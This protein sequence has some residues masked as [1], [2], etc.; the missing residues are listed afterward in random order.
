MQ[1]VDYA[2]QWADEPMSDIEERLAW[3][4][5]H[6]RQSCA[7]PQSSLE[8]RLRTFTNGS[9]HHVWQCMGCGEQ[10]GN[11]LGGKAARALLG[12][13]TA[14]AFDDQ[15][16]EEYFAQRVALSTEHTALNDIKLA[17]ERPEVLANM[18]A[19]READEARALRV[20]AAVARCVE[21]LQR[22]ITEPQV[23]DALAKEAIAM[24]RRHR[25]VLI[26]ATNRFRS[27]PELKEW[28]EL[29][30]AQ[31]FI[32][33]PEVVGKHTSEGVRVQIDYVAYPRQHLIDHGFAPVYFGIEVK[34]LDQT[35]GFTHKASRAVWQTVSYT[36][37]VFSVDGEMRRLKFALLF[38]N[39]GFEGE[40][41]L[42]ENLGMQ[43][44]N[45]WV[46]WKSLLQLAN[47]ANV[48][49]LDILGT[50]DAW[51][52]WSMAFSSGRYFRRTKKEGAVAY[53]LS[54]AR[55]INKVRIGNF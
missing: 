6:L 36:D 52:G 41:A 23:A 29:H 47:H 13:S 5:E 46:T 39:L 45:E 20:N 53:S 37:S 42:L 27:E 7:C 26:D 22:E 25:Q 8:V 38:S 1:A 16:H 18:R 19:S 28:L 54:N 14:A 55:M 43:R 48:G 35:E 34:Y 24:R 30:L 51:R 10:R 2:A 50:R 21:E 40:L 17:R 31:D 44:E 33:W 4:E 9:T 11:A 3:L 49:T 32:L 12:S 15:V